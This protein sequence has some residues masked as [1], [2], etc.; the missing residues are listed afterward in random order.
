MSQRIAEQATKTAV[1]S[2]RDM[3]AITV[4]AMLFL[5]GTAVAVRF[6]LSIVFPSS[7]LIHICS[8]YSA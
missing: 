7:T 2:K 4:L 1:A 8:L 6:A 3:K 5:P